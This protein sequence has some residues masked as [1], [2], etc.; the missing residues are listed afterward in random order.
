MWLRLLFFKRCGSG[1]LVLWSSGP[2]VQSGP[3]GR[4]GQAGV[5][6]A[7]HVLSGLP[8]NLHMSCF[9]ALGLAVYGR[10]SRRESQSRKAMCLPV[11]Q[12][13]LLNPKH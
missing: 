9:A 6:L 8:E 11:F 7:K 2:L 13:S 1:P 4:A 3:Y 10:A 12:G 5:S